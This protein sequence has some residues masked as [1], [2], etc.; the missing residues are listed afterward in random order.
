MP[1]SMRCAW[2]MC[3]RAGPESHL[4]SSRNASQRND[5]ARPAAN[6]R[7]RSGTGI[8]GAGP[9]TVH[10]PSGA[11]GTGQAGWSVHAGRPLG[12][13]K[14]ETA[15]ALAQ[16]YGSGPESL[17]TLNM[18]EFQEAHTVSAL[19]GA[20][21]GYVGYGKGGRLTEAVR[22]RPHCVLLLDE[23]EKAHPDVR[24]MFYRSWIRAGWKTPK[25]NA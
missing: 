25:G 24:E 22:K 6:L 9:Q 18:S 20:P 7:G 10:H 13:G 16:V 8:E 12:V 1:T 3:F 21:A 2:R 19:K 14:T 5:V 15:L 11:A 4:A 23:F 17:I